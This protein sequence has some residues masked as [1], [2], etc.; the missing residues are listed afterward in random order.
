MDEFEPDFDPSLICDP[1]AEPGFLVSL[2]S[3]TSYRLALSRSHELTS[4]IT[5]SQHYDE[6]DPLQARWIPYSPTCEPAPD[7]ISHIRNRD[8]DKLSF[9]A[10]RTILILGDSV[11]RNGIHHMAEMLGLPRYVVPYDD[12]SKKGVVPPGWDDRGLP[13]VVEIPWTNTY[14]TNGFMYGLVRH[15]SR[16]SCST[17]ASSSPADPDSSLPPSRISLAH[18]T[19]RTT[20]DSSPT[21]TRRARPRTASTRSSRCT[22]TSCRSRRPSSRCTRA[23]RPSP[24][25]SYHPRV[26]LNADEET[27]RL[28]VWDLAFFG[29]QD[30]VS[31]LS[32][33]IPLTHARVEW[34]QRRLK[35]VIGHVNT[36]WPGVPLWLRKL[37]RVGPVGPASCASFT[38][39]LRASPLSLALGE[40]LLPSGC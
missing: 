19:T 28:A 16:S 25:L 15:L 33:E 13:W 12:Y 1:F 10:N 22:R 14:F 24:T 20:S 3:P 23:V 38:S 39:S 21:G 7:W 9:L 36:T 6:D 5:P 31:R 8:L 11:D 34:W 37:H 2:A 40:P 29:R 35:E 32:T 4:A 30:R 18:R 26:H 27:S 17:T